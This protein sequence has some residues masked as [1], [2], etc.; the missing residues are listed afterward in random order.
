MNYEYRALT[1]RGEWEYGVINDKRNKIMRGYT[2]LPILPETVS[3]NTYCCDSKGHLAF[4]GDIVMPSE[5]SRVPRTLKIITYYP[6]RATFGLKSYGVAGENPWY[7]FQEGQFEIVGN[8]YEN[9]DLLPDPKELSN[10]PNDNE[11]HVEND[12]DVATIH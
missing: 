3:K 2:F 7:E 1:Q 10:L 12:E 9:K 4:E 11:L 5:N 6:Y 8:I